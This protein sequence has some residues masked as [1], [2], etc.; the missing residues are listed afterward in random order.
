M[1]AEIGNMD[2]CF[3]YEGFGC[4]HKRKCFCGWVR[5]YWNMHG[6]Y[7]MHVCGYGVFLCVLHNFIGVLVCV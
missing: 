1:E 5:D 6:Y 7:Y 4:M 3:I 2:F